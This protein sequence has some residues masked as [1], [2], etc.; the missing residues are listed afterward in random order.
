MAKAKKKRGEAKW[1]DLHGSLSRSARRRGL[2]G[3]R[4]KA[5]IYGTKRKLGWQPRKKRYG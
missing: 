1:R 2:T 3:K 4:R 5:Y